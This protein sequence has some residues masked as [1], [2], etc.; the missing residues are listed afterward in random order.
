MDEEI[1]KKR[2]LKAVRIHGSGDFYSQEYLDKWISIAKINPSIRFYCYTKSLHLD[3]SNLPA[4]FV[5]IQSMGGNY[6]HLI[7]WKRSVA[8]VF[9][10]EEMAQF[11]NDLEM[12]HGGNAFWQVGNADDGL[13][14][15]GV[16]LIAL[17]K[18]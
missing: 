11:D 5:V 3:W 8:R 10:S 6:D 17:I 14:A 16:K 15:N 9:E 13:A 1:S 18:H 12:A 4:N 7:D 2:G